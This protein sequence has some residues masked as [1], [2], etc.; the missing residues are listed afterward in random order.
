MIIMTINRVLKLHKMWINDAPSG[1]CANL[2]GMDLRNEEL[3]DVNLKGA[4]L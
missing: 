4:I 3:Y 2:S 1:K